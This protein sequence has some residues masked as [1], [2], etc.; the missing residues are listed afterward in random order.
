[1]FRGGINNKWVNQR[2]TSRIWQ[3]TKRKQKEFMGMAMSH[4]IS[5][6]TALQ[7]IIVFFHGIKIHLFLQF[8]EK[9]KLYLS[10]ILFTLKSQKVIVAADQLTREAFNCLK[11]KQTL[12]W[13]AFYIQDNNNF[14]EAPNPHNGIVHV[15]W[16][17]YQGTY[18]LPFYFEGYIVIP[19]VSYRYLPVV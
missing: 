13:S 9:A 12:P 11:K 7:S 10:L 6:C 14:Y 19:I 8:W 1:M 15:S 2:I 16:G 17:V 18:P 5:T 4:M 3:M